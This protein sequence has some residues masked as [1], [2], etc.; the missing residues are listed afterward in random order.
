MKK[1]FPIL[2]VLALIGTACQLGGSAQPT[3]IPAVTAFPTNAIN[4]NPTAAPG[5]NQA[6][7]STRNSN[8]GMTEIYIPTGTFTQGGLDPNATQ[9][10]KPAHK[11]TMHAYWIDKFDV[12]NAMYLQCVSAGACNPPQSFSS[13]TVTNYFNNKDYNDYPVVQ[14]TWGDAAAYC[15]W[16]GRRLPTEAE[17]EYAARGTTINTYPWGN[18]APDNTRANFNSAVGDTTKVGSFPAGASPFGVLDMAGNVYQWV[19]DFYDANYYSKGVVLNPTGPTART[20]FF[21]RVIKG[22]SFQDVAADIRIANRPQ[23]LGPNPDAQQGSA[24]YLGTFDA[25]IGFR[26]AS[27]N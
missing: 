23:A 27:D 2:A 4:L 1:L 24:A 3:P 21:G 17:W 7:G 13:K 8:D 26:C 15:K 12:T 19:S 10:E 22:G 6:A 14:V 9:D 5:G 18:D 11:V 20:N 25:K 16:A